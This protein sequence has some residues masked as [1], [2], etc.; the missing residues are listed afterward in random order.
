MGAKNASF[1]TR[2]G[3]LA[4]KVKLPNT[5]LKFVIDIPTPF[6]TVVMDLEEK[7]KLEKKISEFN[8]SLENKQAEK[9][10]VNQQLKKLGDEVRRVGR[11]TVSYTHLTLP[12]KA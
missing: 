8:S 4:C 2:Y 11:E 5:Y 6:S 12:T 7:E 3:A 9:K 1:W 10:V